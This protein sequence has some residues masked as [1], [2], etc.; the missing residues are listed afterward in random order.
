W[1]KMRH[2]NVLPCYGLCRNFGPFPGLVI[3]FCEGGNIL[4]YLSR[5][6]AMDRVQLL[7]SISA[8]LR[9]LHSKGVVHGDLRACNILMDSQG[10]PR[11]SDAGLCLVLSEAD[12]TRISV[13]GV[14]R[15]TAPEVLLDEGSEIPFTKQSD[16]YSFAMT[17][18][19]ILTGRIPFELIRQDSVVILAVIGGAR[20]P[21]PEGRIDDSI[22]EIIET[23]WTR[24]PK[25]R[26]NA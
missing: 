7:V 12:F 22:W 26:P 2:R 19:E 13:G 10:V 20:P 25:E 23:C 15:W 21:R 6:P 9:Y 3:P 5:H 17:M 18:L 11:L 4:Q 8:G 1:V 14:S 24:N 16:M